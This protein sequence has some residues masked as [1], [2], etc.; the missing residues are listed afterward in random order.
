[1]LVFYII[2]RDNRDAISLLF[3]LLFLRVW[4]MCFKKILG[5]YVFVI[6]LLLVAGCGIFETR[7]PDDPDGSTTSGDIALSA[8]EVFEYIQNAFT[9]RDHDLYLGVF[10]ESFIS[11][12][13]GSFADEFGEW[14]FNQ[15]NNFI[16]SLFS[17]S[18]LPADSLLLI[19]FPNLTIQSNPNP[20]TAFVQDQLYQVEVHSTD[21]T[22][23]NEYSGSMDVTLYRDLDGGWRITKWVD[24]V[25]GDEASF[26]HLRLWA[27][28]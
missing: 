16:Y 24:H 27:L 1:M 14:T 8:D 12:A 4:T 5:I 22:L 17:P 26:S 20:D 18:V 7:D 23:S 19:D 28:Q 25:S 15:E 6:S 2:K 21:G 11:V 9:H 3:S 10:H 13:T